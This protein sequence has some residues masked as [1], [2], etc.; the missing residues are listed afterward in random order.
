MANKKL[1][2]KNLEILSELMFLEELAYKKCEVYQ[3]QF[4]DGALQK[5]CQDLAGNHKARFD[6]LH[7][8]LD[9]HE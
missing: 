9:S 6:A 4:K 2:A 1:A 5:Q 7:T 8:Y 3:K